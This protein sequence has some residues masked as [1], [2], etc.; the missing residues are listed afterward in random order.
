MKNIVGI[1]IILISVDTSYSQLKTTENTAIEKAILNYIQ[2]FF[3]N[4]YAAMNES[5]HT[6]LAKRGLNTDGT[7]TGDP[8][9]N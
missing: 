7:L 9:R 4:N 2:N 1:L 8:L 3:E 5:L 6:K